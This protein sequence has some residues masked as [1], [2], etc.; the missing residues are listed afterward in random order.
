MT[1]PLSATGI[2]E[3]IAA[4]TMLVG[5]SGAMLLQWKLV[6]KA[7]TNWGF[8]VRVIQFVAVILV[9]PAIVILSLEKILTSETT[10]TLVGALIGY[11]F[12]GLGELKSQQSGPRAAEGKS[13]GESSTSG[14]P[15]PRT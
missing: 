13:A 5:L 3:L 12:S 11:M 2:I 6:A 1:G 15:P 8:D 4:A 9:I 14:G 7:S 10:A